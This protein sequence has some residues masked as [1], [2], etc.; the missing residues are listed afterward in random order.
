VVATL[1]VLSQQG[2]SRTGVLIFSGIV[3][4]IVMFVNVA[5]DNVKQKKKNSP[6]PELSKPDFAVPELPNKESDHV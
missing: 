5:F 1:R 2:T 6:R 3:V 4:A